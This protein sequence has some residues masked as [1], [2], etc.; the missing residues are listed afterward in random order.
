[1]T[2]KIGRND[3]CPCGSGKKY[4]HCCMRTDTDNSNTYSSGRSL[5]QSS[6]LD[7]PKLKAYMASHDCAP[8]LD[9]LIALQMNPQNHGKNLR[10][11]HIAQLAVSSL[12]KSSIAPSIDVVKK[13]I[14]EEYPQDVMEDIP[15]NMYAETVV[16][17]GGNYM[18]FPGLST[19]VAELFRAMT[20]A[21]Y[22]RDDIF[23]SDYQREVFQGVSILL[24]LGDLIAFGAGI[25]GLVRGNENPRELVTDP[26]AE[27]SY[28]INERMMTEILQHYG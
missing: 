6:G 12:G 15:M 10:I 11:E 23:K 24:E 5:L 27:Y 13:L 19:H 17:H 16:F 18:F 26:N 21:I 20:E 4:K 8:I 25:T 14:D 3:P 28:V 7:A 2:K 1:M 9:Y 22:Y